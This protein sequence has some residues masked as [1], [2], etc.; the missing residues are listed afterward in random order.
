MRECIICTESTNPFTAVTCLHEKCSMIAHPNCWNGVI[1]KRKCPACRQKTRMRYGLCNS[2]HLQIIL[3]LCFIIF[4][5]VCV[6]REPNTSPVVYSDKCGGKY[7][8]QNTTDPIKTWL[9]NISMCAE[10]QELCKA[11]SCNKECYDAKENLCYEISHHLKCQRLATI[12]LYDDYLTQLERKIFYL[13]CRKM[14][15]N[16]QKSSTDKKQS[17]DQKPSDNKQSTDQRQVSISDF[18]KPVLFSMCFIT[19][20]FLT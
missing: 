11:V 4:L 7:V 17:T 9:N 19:Y 13:T 8:S 20:A 12:D 1:N 10:E 2:E 14:L 6:A 18:W 16:D 5:M 3:A 15:A